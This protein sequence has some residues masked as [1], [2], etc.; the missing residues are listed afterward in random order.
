YGIVSIPTLNVFAGGE[1]VKSV[2]GARPKA[3][4]AG[5]IEDVLTTV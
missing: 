4:Y 2:I 1:L 5:E 3:F